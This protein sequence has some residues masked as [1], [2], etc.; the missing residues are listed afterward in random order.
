MAALLQYQNWCLCSTD[1]SVSIYEEMEYLC[2]YFTDLSTFKVRVCLVLSQR[3]WEFITLLDTPQSLQQTLCFGRHSLFCLCPSAGQHLQSENCSFWL[4]L[5]GRKSSH[6]LCTCSQEMD[7]IALSI[8][9]GL[10]EGEGTMCVQW[11]VS[12]LTF[13]YSGDTLC[14]CLHKP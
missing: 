7:S 6:R 8:E 11:Q 2:S 9:H 13:K 4:S 5:K 1:L 3:K 14:P 10:N 12:K